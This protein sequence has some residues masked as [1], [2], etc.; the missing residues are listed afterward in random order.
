VP[1]IGNIPLPSI[2]AELEI[3]DKRIGARVGS[4]HDPVIVDFAFP[5]A[6]HGKTSGIGEDGSP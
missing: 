2:L 1:A 4:D 3:V 6:E 5:V